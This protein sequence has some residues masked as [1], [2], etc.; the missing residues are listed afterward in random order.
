M[1]IMRSGKLKTDFRLKT[2]VLFSLSGV[3]PDAPASGGDYRAEQ[4]SPV[5]VLHGALGASRCQG[6]TAGITGWDFPSQL[7]TMK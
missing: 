5:Q 1:L 2:L 6:G 4:V 3:Y 7:S